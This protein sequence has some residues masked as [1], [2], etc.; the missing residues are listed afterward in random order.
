MHLVRL[1]ER[2]F[3]Q[4][5]TSITSVLLV[6]CLSLLLLGVGLLFLQ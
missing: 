4:R 1:I 6:L 5:K 3:P 2:R